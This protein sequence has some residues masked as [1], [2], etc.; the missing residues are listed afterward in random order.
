MLD[1][2]RKAGD[3][4]AERQRQADEAAARDKAQQGLASLNMHPP[5]Y[6]GAPPQSYPPPQ[7]VDALC[8]HQASWVGPDRCPFRALMLAILF[9]LF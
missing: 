3:V 9:S 8:F 1:E 2:L 7:Q 5:P 6:G 4:A